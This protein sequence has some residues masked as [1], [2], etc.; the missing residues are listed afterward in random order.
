MSI[1]KLIIS[2][3]TIV[4]QVKIIEKIK[5]K[6]QIRNLLYLI[7]SIIAQLITQN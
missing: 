5:K 4:K 3:E 6:V 7:K 1:T 2:L